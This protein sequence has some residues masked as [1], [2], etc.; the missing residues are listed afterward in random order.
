MDNTN[1]HV[2]VYNHIFFSFA[3]ETVDSF[4]QEKGPDACPT[5]S[6]ANSDLRNLK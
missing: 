6:T 3:V 5:V 4:K 1:Q 2:Y